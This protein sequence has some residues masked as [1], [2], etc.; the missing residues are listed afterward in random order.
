MRCVI[1]GMI[2]SH[3]EVES[4]LFDMSYVISQKETKTLKQ[5]VGKKSQNVPN[6][7]LL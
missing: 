3:L 6:R 5:Y 7:S 1:K 2:V 4:K